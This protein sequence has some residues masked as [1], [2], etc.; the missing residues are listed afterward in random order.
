MINKCPGKMMASPVGLDKSSSVTSLAE[1]NAFILLP[2]GTRGFQ[3]TFNKRCFTA[4]L[5]T[6]DLDDRERI[7]HGH[8]LPFITD[9]AENR[10]L[11]L[12][13]KTRSVFQKPGPRLRQ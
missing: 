6:Y 10:N 7:D 13:E 1:A 9:M 8:S 2:G 4:V 5:K 3:H 11:F 12:T